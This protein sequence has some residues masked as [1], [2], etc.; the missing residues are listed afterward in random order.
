MVRIVV[1]NETPGGRQRQ[2]E[3]QVQVSFAKVA[4]A[5]LEFLAGHHQADAVEAMREFVALHD[6]AEA[7]S[8]DPKGIVVRT[9]NLDDKNPDNVP[10]NNILRGSLR[11]VAAMVVE[12]A[13]QADAETLDYTVTDAGRYRA[14]RDEI[15]EG[16]E[17]LNAKV[18]RAKARS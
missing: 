8:R 9:P 1:D 11:M 16:V 4:S 12:A 13:E 17:L 14:A 5:T 10:I 2:L 6:A 18:A 15:A 7:E 3:A